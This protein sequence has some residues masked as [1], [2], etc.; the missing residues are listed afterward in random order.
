MITARDVMSGASI[1]RISW[2]AIERACVREIRTEERGVRLDDL[3]SAIEKELDES[4]RTL[5]PHNCKKYL[6]DLPHDADVVR[7]EPITRKA[8]R[9]YRYLQ[10][11]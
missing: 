5:T 2:E 1:A 9:R 3:L 11:A 4:I 6:T 10:V 7:V 8:S